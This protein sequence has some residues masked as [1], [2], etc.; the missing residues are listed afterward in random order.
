MVLE[1]PEES[2]ALPD[3]HQQPSPAV[4]VLLV[5]LEM[6]GQVVDTLGEQRDLDLRRTGVRG[7]LA[8]RFDNGLAV[9]HEGLSFAR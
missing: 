3:H 7:V 5:D 1:I 6:F 2:P 8:E 9:V 4:V